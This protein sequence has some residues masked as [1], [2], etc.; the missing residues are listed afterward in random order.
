MTI[1]LIA[2]LYLYLLFILAWFAFSLIALYHIIKFG[3]INFK[4]LSVTFAYLVVSTV[5]IS[6]SYAYLSQINWGVS[7]TI[8]QG[9]VNFLGTA[10]F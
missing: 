3:Q 6:L 8:F 10:N 9:G 5:I 2:F 1:P 7:L 4:S